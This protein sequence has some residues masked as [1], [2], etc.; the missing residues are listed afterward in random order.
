M[1][2]AKNYYGNIDGITAFIVTFSLRN[3][4][5]VWGAGSCTTRTGK[6]LVVLKEEVSSHLIQNHPFIVG[7]G[8]LASQK[9]SNIFTGLRAILFRCLT[10]F[11]RELI[12]NL[13]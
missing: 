12:K 10:W 2:G 5:L 7:S 3:L 6:L 8:E 9:Y 1:Y 11:E 13:I 4:C